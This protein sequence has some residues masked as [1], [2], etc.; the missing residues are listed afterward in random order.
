M[1]ARTTAQFNGCGRRH[2]AWFGSIVGVVMLLVG[3]AMAYSSRNDERIRVLETRNAGM[4]EKLDAQADDLR[5]IKQDVK[6][7]LRERQ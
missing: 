3:A 4:A 7:L 2:L 5:E 1:T 6:T